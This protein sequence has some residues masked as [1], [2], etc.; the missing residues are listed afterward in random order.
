MSTKGK[1]LI[2]LF[3]TD[4]AKT[5]V[6]LMDKSTL[7]LE[8]AMAAGHSSVSKSSGSKSPRGVTRENTATIGRSSS[9]AGNKSPRG[10]PSND[11]DNPFPQV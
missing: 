5:I 10:G 9:G 8:K 3:D 1:T 6:S 7:S 4:Q 11:R 2:Y